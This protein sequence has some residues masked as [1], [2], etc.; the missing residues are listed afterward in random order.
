MYGRDE[1]FSPLAGSYDASSA[2]YV[3]VGEAAPVPG[4]WVAT[5][6]ALLHGILLHSGGYQTHIS[7]AQ[8]Q[9]ARSA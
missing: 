8:F 4:V 1:L 9:G 3:A 5:A 6:D 2:Q 7:L